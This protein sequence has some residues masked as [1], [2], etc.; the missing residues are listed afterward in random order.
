MRNALQ[1]IIRAFSISHLT[2]EDVEFCERFRISTAPLKGL[3]GA[4]LN[5]A[6]CRRALTSEELPLNWWH[7][8]ELSVDIHAVSCLSLIH[9]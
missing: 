2:P 9:I 1:S 4:E 8:E 7:D 6:I 5:K 3:K